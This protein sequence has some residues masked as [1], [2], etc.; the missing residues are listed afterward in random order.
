MIL[1][2]LVGIGGKILGVGSGQGFMQGG[3]FSLFN[4]NRT[5][6]P[7]AQAG[8]AI[9]PSLGWQSPG[10][11]NQSPISGGISFGQQATSQA[12]LP[13]ILAIG[14]IIVLLF[15]NIGGKR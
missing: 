8:S 2:G 13:I 9:P 7:Y 1:S 10:S 12:N 15:S 14:A 3:I 6:M 5:N 11:Y 4:R